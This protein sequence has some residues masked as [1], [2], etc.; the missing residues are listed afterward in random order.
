M[1]AKRSGI[2]QEA[3]ID[4]LCTPGH[5]GHKHGRERRKGVKRGRT[6]GANVV[7]D[8]AGALVGVDMGAKVKV[9]LVLDQQ[10]LHGGQ[11]VHALL[12]LALASV[13]R[14]RWPVA[15]PAAKHGFIVSKKK[16]KK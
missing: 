13:G 6:R 11:E 7:G 14:I 1:S 15:S 8:G 12:V 9:D 16:K 5:R 2:D 4:Q 3:L 10:R